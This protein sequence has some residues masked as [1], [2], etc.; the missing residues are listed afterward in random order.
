MK[1]SLIR[2]GDDRGDCPAGIRQ[3]AVS[4]PIMRVPANA[5]GMSVVV[6][7]DRLH[8]AHVKP[9]GV[10]PYQTADSI[11]PRK[12][13][14]QRGAVIFRTSVRRTKKM[15]R[16]SD[17]TFAGVANLSRTIRSQLDVEN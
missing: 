15:I 7:Q 14:R 16:V 1:S 12:R 10:L 4:L 17:K 6:G 3:H 2:F 8:E 11:E 5:D 9:P 13:I